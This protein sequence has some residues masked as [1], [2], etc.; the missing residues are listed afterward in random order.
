M[1]GAAFTSLDFWGNASLLRRSDGQAFVETNGNRYRVRSPFNLGTEDP[2]GEWQML[3]AET[4]GN[5]NQILWRNNP[6]NFLHVWNLDS[7]W[8][9]QSSAGTIDPTS[10]Q[11]STL[12]AQFGLT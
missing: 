11:G 6:G 5:Q 12:L 1:I 2:S 8:N 9:W 4:V 10:P 7:S 3:A